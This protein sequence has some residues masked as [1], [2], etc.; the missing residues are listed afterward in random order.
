MDTVSLPGAQP[1]AVG[2]YEAGNKIYVADDNSGNLLVLDGTT[3]EVLTTILVGA[4]VFDIAVDESMGKVYTA[5]SDD[6]VTTGIGDGN[7]LVS[8]I[9]AGTDS[10]VAQIDPAGP[11]DP[12]RAKFFTF[13]HDEAQDRLYL[14]FYR[15]FGGANIGVIGADNTFTTIGGEVAALGVSG[16]E[17]NS[18]TNTAYIAYNTGNDL[19]VIDGSTLDV[20][21]EDLGHTGGHGP[22][23]IAVNEMEN[24]VYLTMMS[25]PGQGEIGL[26]ALDRDNGTYVFRGADD[27]EPLT[28]N[29]ATNRLFSGV[30]VGQHGAVVDG[31]TDALTYVDLGGSGMGAGDVRQSTDN[32]YFASSDET[33]VVNGSTLRHRKFSAAPTSGGVFASSVTIDQARGLVYVVNNDQD[34][35]ITVIH[36]SEIPAPTLSVNDLT[37][38]ERDAGSRAATLTVR[39]SEKTGRAV[40]FRYE[41]TS[42]TATPDADYRT[43]AGT[44]T[45][46]AESLTTSVTIPVLGDSVDEAGQTFFLDLTDPVNATIADSRGVVTIADDDPPAGVSIRNASTIEGDSGRHKMFFRVVLNA[47]SEKPVAVKFRTFNG[48]AKAPSDYTGKSGT[49]R[50]AKGVTAK[51]VY[52]YVKGDRRNEPREHFVV[53]LQGPV[54]ASIADRSGRG[55]IRDDD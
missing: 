9:D 47:P 10:I 46:P 19:V 4:A 21:T 24:K 1:L 31:A 15:P 27:L 33:F 51:R 37:I 8:V 26:L 30:Q 38:A 2:V 22:L 35:I 18:S 17:V 25:V 50:F 11:D 55:L 7:G 44:G 39:L 49:V 34:G 29:P 36:D 54:N 12:G 42:G 45:I 20:T 3:R 16:I 23:D 53:K 5:S 13:G 40:T 6:L 28:F 41:S 32:A 48:T 43:V 14:T 52:V